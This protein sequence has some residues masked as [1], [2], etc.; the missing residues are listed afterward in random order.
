MKMKERFNK[1]KVFLT[2]NLVNALVLFPSVA[3]AD[4]ED[5]FNKVDKIAKDTTGKLKLVSVGLFILVI[6]VAGIVI[7]LGGQD[8][9]RKAKGRLGWVVLAIII[10]ASAAAAVPWVMSF[11]GG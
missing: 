11:V 4:G 2:F 9:Q 3:L 10:V 8:L 5:P 7:A 1:I 6:V